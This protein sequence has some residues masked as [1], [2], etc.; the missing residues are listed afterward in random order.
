MLESVEVSVEITFTLS[1]S[2]KVQ[3]LCHKGCKD[4]FILFLLNVQRS[5]TSNLAV[6][7]AQTLF[8]IAKTSADAEEVCNVA[9]CLVF[10]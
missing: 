10:A 7:C 9:F 5:E 4:L 2:H 8:T 1:C 6:Q 3:L